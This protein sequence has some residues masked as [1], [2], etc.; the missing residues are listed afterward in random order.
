MKRNNLSKL[1]NYRMTVYK[2]L[3]L[4]NLKNNKNE[5]FFN[6]FIL[7]SDYVY[8]NLWVDI[9]TTYTNFKTNL[10]KLDKLVDMFEKT[11]D[12]I[13]FKELFQLDKDWYEY[14][15]CN[16]DINGNLINNETRL[17]VNKYYVK[18]ITY[19]QKRLNLN[20]DD[21]LTFYV[22]LKFILIGNVKMI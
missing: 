12:I 9:C 6:R 19:I 15:K 17:G 4:K 7:N 18:D 5:L 1:I 14:Y 21:A 3:L 2:K 8:F 13:L 11:N 16:A 22:K 10:K 20:L